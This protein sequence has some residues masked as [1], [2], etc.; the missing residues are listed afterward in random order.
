MG[1]EGTGAD[2]K[3]R[4]MTCIREMKSVQTLISFPSHNYIKPFNKLCRRHMY[5]IHLTELT[6]MTNGKMIDLIL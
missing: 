3:E 2:R 4:G 6:D 1:E 5:V